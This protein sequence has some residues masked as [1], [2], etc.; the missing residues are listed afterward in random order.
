MARDKE[1][2]KR[3]A[4]E[5]YERNKELTKERAR[6]RDLANPEQAAAR[7]A[8]WRL[9]NKE[10]HNSINRAW[11]LKNKDRKAALQAKRRAAQ[12]QRTPAWLTAEDHRLMADYYQMAKEL[13][14]IFPWKQHVDHIVPLQGKLVSGLHTPLNLQILSE[15]ANLQ[16]SNK[17]TI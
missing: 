5:W 14:A 2:Q 4:K 16:K 15:A 7:K 3:L 13:E 11:G 1:N 9:E 6:A 8:K 12:L 17:T 10:M